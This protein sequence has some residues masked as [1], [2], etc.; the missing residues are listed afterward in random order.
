MGQPAVLVQEEPKVQL[1]KLV[2]R[3]TL[4]CKVRRAPQ[5]LLEQK[6]PQE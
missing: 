1:D 4:V 6:G 2:T 5:G 3:V